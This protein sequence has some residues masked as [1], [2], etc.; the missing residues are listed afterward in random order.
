MVGAQQVYEEGVFLD[1][2]DKDFF[3]MPATEEGMVV[4]FVR[5]EQGKL[6]AMLPE[7]Y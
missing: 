5:N 7:D 3:V 1:D 2:Q 4:W 6:T